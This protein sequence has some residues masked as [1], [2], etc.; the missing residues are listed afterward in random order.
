MR[1]EIEFKP[2][3]LMRYPTVGDYFYLSDGTLKIEIADTSNEFYNKMILIHELVEEAITK[4]NGITE[5]QIMD[6]DLAFEKARELGLKTADEEP[7]FCNDAPYKEAHYYATS[8]EMGMCALTKTS[9]K[10]YDYAV[11]SL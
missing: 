6:F 1:I 5:Q 2:V 4:K 3:H 8:V 7:G 9:W 11:N 10:D